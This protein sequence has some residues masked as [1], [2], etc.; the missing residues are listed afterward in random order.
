MTLLK[1]WVIKVQNT[2][3]SIDQEME[4]LEGVAKMRVGGAKEVGP[5]RE[6][7]RQ[8][9]KPFVITKDTMKVSSVA[10]I[11]LTRDG[12]DTKANTAIFCRTRYLVQGTPAYQP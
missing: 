12:L 7:Q 2:L 10:H 5:P 3:T 8:P 6:S 4:L 11:I 9:M 1:L